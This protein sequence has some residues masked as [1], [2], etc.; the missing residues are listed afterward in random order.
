MELHPGKVSAVVITIVVIL[1]SL[2]QVTPLK[3]NPWD[4]ILGWFGNKFNKKTD[5]KLDKI[6]ERVDYLETKFDKMESDIK[7]ETVRKWRYDI[8]DFCNAEINH[9][10]HTKEQFD[11]VLDSCK[12]YE[13]YCKKNEVDNGKADMAIRTIRKRYDQHAEN[14]DFLKEDC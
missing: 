6:S 12:K 14:E 11:E 4:K 8:L 9:R 10:R 3:L 5:E 7:N 13:S 1:L 2:I